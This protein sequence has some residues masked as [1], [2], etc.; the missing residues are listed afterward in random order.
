MIGYLNR[1]RLT[2]L[3]SVLVVILILL[4]LFLKEGP[5]KH[6]GFA[7][8]VPSSSADP[9]CS[10]IKLSSPDQLSKLSWPTN[11]QVPCEYVVE[12]SRTFT[13]HLFNDYDSHLV[14]AV[15]G[16]GIVDV[17]L[18]KKIYR[19]ESKDGNFKDY[20]LDVSEEVSRYANVNLKIKRVQGGIFIR[21]RADVVTKP[22][23]IPRVANKN[24]DSSSY[25]QIGIV[26]ILSL[27][28][29]GNLVYGFNLTMPY[30]WYFG[31]SLLMFISPK[32]MYYFDEWHIL[33]RFSKMGFPGV[34]HTH[35]EH[36]IIA[37]F[38][39]YY[40]LV[41][42]FGS[43]YY[44]LLV[45]SVFL[46]I[47]CAFSVEKLLLMYELDKRAVRA[48]IV[49]F[50]LSALHAEVLHWAFEQSIILS[51]I[52]GLWG[53]IFLKKWTSTLRLKEILLSGFFL[54][55]SPLFF[56]N[57]FIFFPL[58]AFFL[59]LEIRLVNIKR[60]FYAGACLF[61][62]AIPPVII[63]HLLKHAS[64]GHGVDSIQG[65]F[66]IIKILS[67]VLV[68]S[69]LGTIGR[70]LGLYPNMTLNS[71][72]TFLYE[73]FGHYVPWLDRGVI[74]NRSVETSLGLY[75]W[76]VLFLVLLVLMC[77]NKS[78]R[79][80]IVP[81][82][83]GFSLILISFL[84]PAIGRTHLGELQSLSL[85]YQYSSMIGFSILMSPIFFIFYSNHVCKVIFSVFI[86][87]WVS[88]QAFLVQGFTYFTDHGDLHGVYVSELFDWN[89]R[90]MKVEGTPYEGT[91]EMSGLFPLARPSITPGSHPI[92]ILRTAKWLRGEQD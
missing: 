19:I 31:I 84:L 56:G 70:G 57:G 51:C 58:A 81:C 45:V 28:L 39:W 44:A 91:A 35:N 73:V 5:S 43:N 82:L 37:F 6:L 40:G 92:D 87:L 68:G 26:A 88:E 60:Y 33:A 59:I 25:V 89:N 61:V 80:F 90:A 42:F 18:G 54:C 30:L 53:L 9:L 16:R 48:S 20:F 10:S 69:G 23:P 76:V 14:L 86:F 2:R 50:V 49:F 27:V 74:L 36:S 66:D 67:Y 78:V 7:E 4:G 11:S 83:F 32:L 71:V 62:S 47:V 13:Q 38:I 77:L 21:S 15:S 72:Q 17:Y 63:Y 75:L 12:V 65:G 64:A 22:Y 29:I 79:K 34:I 52:S 46:H 1:D 41:Q 85:R 24:L 55:L 3:L 8:L